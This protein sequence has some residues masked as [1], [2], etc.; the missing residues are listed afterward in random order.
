[1]KIRPFWKDVS[2]LNCV[3]HRIHYRAPGQSGLVES[4]GTR[5]MKQGR[6][7]AP[8]GGPVSFFGFG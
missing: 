2:A 7:D 5:T 4:A 3:N 8:M 6:L 1:M